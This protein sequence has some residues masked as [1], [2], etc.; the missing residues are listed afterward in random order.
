MYSCD[1]NPILMCWIH[2]S[3]ESIPPHQPI[4]SPFLGG[5]IISLAP[6]SHCS[7][8]LHPPFSLLG[9]PYLARIIP[10]MKPLVYPCASMDPL[11]ST[12]LILFENSTYFS[13]AFVVSIYPLPPLGDQYLLWNP[14]SFRWHCHFLNNLCRSPPPRFFFSFPL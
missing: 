6:S 1:L 10:L 7:Q 9:L 3:I 2:I 4:P 13:L 8:F 5:S 12:Y 11:L 14:S